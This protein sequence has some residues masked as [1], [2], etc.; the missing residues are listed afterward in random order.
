MIEE[1][2]VLE[3]KVPSGSGIRL[4]IRARSVLDGLRIGDS[5]SANGICLT[6]VEIGSGGFS[7]QAVKET[8]ENSTIPDWGI[9]KTL[10]L[11]RSLA[12]GDRMGGHIVQGHVDGVGTVKSIVRR[13]LETSVKI[14]TD[15]EIMRYVVHKGSI[16]VDGISLTVAGVEGDEFSV[17]IIPHTWENTNMRELRIGDRVN[18]ETDILARYVEKF[19]EG[20]GKKSGL[21][22]EA[23]RRAGF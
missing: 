22:E 21:T 17:A 16:A 9:G 6:V 20:G 12:L 7:V 4:Q 15:S 8:V 2:G 14:S 18:L 1:T 23:L 13:E 5:V 10:N 11:E 19:L 3:R